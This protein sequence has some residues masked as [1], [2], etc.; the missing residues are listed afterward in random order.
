MAKKQRDGLQNRYARVRIPLGPP[1]TKQQ[2]VP[3]DGFTSSRP[4]LALQALPRREKGARIADWCIGTSSP[5][6]LPS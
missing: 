6:K 4:N 5:S 2:A 1:D 3:K